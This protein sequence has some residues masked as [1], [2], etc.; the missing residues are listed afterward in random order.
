VGEKG[1]GEIKT[2]DRQK[3]GL[4]KGNTDCRCCGWLLFL[5]LAEK[6]GLCWIAVLV[7]VPLL[8]CTGE[9]EEGDIF[10]QQ[11]HVQRSGCQGKLEK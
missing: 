6:D 2:P 5:S 3:L 4:A 1:E 7:H 10:W 11:P 9:K 8:L